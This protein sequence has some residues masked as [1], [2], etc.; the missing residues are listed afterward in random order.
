VTSLSALI[1]AGSRRVPLVNAFR[2]ALRSLGNGRVIVTD[3]NPLSPAVYCADQ[4]YRVPLALEP[5]Y[6]DEIVKIAA[7]ERVRLVVPTIDDELT[8]F[9]AAVDRFAALGVR[10]AVSDPTTTELCNDKSAACRALRAAGINA[11]A[12]FLPHELPSCPAFPLFVKPRFGRG[13]VGAYAIRNRRDLEFFLGYVHDPI[14]QTYLDGPEFT[15]DMLCDFTGRPLAIVPRERVVIRA[16]VSDRGRTVNDP[17]L[18]SLAQSCAS[19]IRFVG[20]I[21]I[22]C[23]VVGG[24][25]I[26]FE[27]N[28]RFSGGIPLT[29]EAGADFPRML[30]LLTLGRH[31]PPA[32]GQFRDNL[33]MTNYEASVFVDAD[34]IA[35][36]PLGPARPVAEVA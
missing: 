3:V 29:I 34:R 26:V 21:N 12:S 6:I 11:A 35:L 28:P 19:A 1:T 7:F 9:A 5:G 31:V 8:V 2:R 15:V 17:A 13:G 33:W 24:R 30:S 10:V 14:I 22:Q 25:P 20:A 16:G 32:I 36:D 23:R 18:I 27:I 4:A